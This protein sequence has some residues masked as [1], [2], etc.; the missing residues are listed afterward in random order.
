MKDADRD[1]T[2]L[3]TRQHREEEDGLRLVVK[4]TQS[5]G[6]AYKEAHPD[7]PLSNGVMMPSARNV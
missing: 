1:G 3:S 7:S 5:A 2:V 6:S 4:G